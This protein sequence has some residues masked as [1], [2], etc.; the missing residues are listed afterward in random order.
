MRR[1]D[2]EER[3]GAEELEAEG[4]HGKGVWSLIS[5]FGGRAKDVGDLQ[6]DIES[7]ASVTTGEG[8][9]LMCPSTNR[10]RSG[11]GDKSG[12]SLPTT[13]LTRRSFQ[14][15]GGVGMFALERRT[16]QDYDSGGNRKFWIP[17]GQR[18]PRGSL[19]GCL[20]L[21]DRVV[22]RYIHD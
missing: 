13:V 15:A 3:S 11:V 16:G 9:V 19:F 2:A 20:S 4:A 18:R 17:C 10:P 7:L 14:F 6:S 21:F 12:S 5:V 8:V 1:R 22:R